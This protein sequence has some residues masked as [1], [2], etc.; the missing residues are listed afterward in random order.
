MEYGKEIDIAN[1]TAIRNPE[2]WSRLSGAESF[3]FDQLTSLWQLHIIQNDCR[4]GAFFGVFCKVA[5][6]IPVKSVQTLVSLA[7]CPTAP[8][9][10]WI[11]CLGQRF[12]L[13]GR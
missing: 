2:D 3:M 8:T 6:A 12:P 4:I 10:E 5:A 13:N 11:Q 7:Q 9:E 1:G